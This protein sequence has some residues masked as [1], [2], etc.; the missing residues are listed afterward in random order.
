MRVIG[1]DPEH[2]LLAGHPVAVLDAPRLVSR[3]EHAAEH[4]DGLI[5]PAD[6]AIP[7]GEE[8]HLHERIEALAG[9]G[10]GGALQ[11][12]VGSTSA[13]VLDEFRGQVP[14][15]LISTSAL[16]KPLDSGRA[17]AN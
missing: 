11:V 9:E 3:L 15:K 17:A 5:D 8:L 7:I 13:V 16:I 6:H 2:D 14:I 10:D 4:V 12:H 1:L